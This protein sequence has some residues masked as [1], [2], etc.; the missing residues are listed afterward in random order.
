MSRAG[1]PLEV[2]GLLEDALEV[3]DRAAVVS[4]AGLRREFLKS[5]RVAASLRRQA[6]TAEAPCHAPAS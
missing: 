3:W 4:R 1:L 5:L 2:T 6:E